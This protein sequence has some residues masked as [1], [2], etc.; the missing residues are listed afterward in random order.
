MNLRNHHIEFRSMSHAPLD[1]GQHILIGAYTELYRLMQTV[2]VPSDALLR[3]PLEIRYA[4]HFSFR[5]LW[6]P[7]FCV[8]S[9]LA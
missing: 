1:N 6:L 7:A 2:G 8:T 5:R 3:M 9:A 4:T